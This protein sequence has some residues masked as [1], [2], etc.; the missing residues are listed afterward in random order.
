[1]TIDNHACIF[2][3]EYEDKTFYSCTYQPR[4]DLPP[5]SLWCAIDESYKSVGI[6]KDSCT[7]S[8]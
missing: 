2:P 1:M 8:T 5:G 3:F 7:K 6:C 4:M